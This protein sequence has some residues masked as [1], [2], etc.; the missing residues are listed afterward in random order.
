M[1]NLATLS[2]LAF[3]P[4]SIGQSFL[5]QNCLFPS[6][7]RN[8]FSLNIDLA[9]V[10]VILSKKWKPL[11]F[12]IEKILPHLA[13][14]SKGIWVHDGATHHHGHDL[15]PQEANFFATICHRDLSVFTAWLPVDTKSEHLA[16][17]SFCSIAFWFLVQ[18]F[19]LDSDMW[20][21]QIRF[22]IQCSFTTQRLF[23]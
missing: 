23:S 14:I 8:K 17:H 3:P 21:L 11:N 22:V 19:E 20:F 12:L 15:H 13:K 16:E 5:L 4:L 7:V 9:S 10:L 18:I 2:A 1:I 6:S